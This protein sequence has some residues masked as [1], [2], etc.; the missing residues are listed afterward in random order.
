NFQ[1]ELE[2]TISTEFQGTIESM[3]NDL[4]EQE[5][6]FV[7]EQSMYQ[8]NKYKSMVRSILKM[9]LDSDTSVETLQ[10]RRRDRADFVIIDK[11]N[12]RLDLIAT[13]ISQKSNKAFNLLKTIE[14]IR[15]LLLDLRH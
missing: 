12:D 1:A 3:M 2:S 8:M 9:L 4:A 15:G 10:R 7:E 14:E 13:T 6:R 5:K 11:I